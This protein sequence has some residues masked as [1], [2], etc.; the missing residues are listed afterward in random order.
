MSLGYILSEGVAGF[1]RA[2]LA[3]FTSITSLV[4]SVLVLGVLARVGYGLYTLGAGLKDDVDIEVFLASSSEAADREVGR[5]LRQLEWVESV[6][7][8][9]RDSAAAVFL[10]EF[11]ADGTPLVELDFLPASYR[12]RP[13]SELPAD[14]IAARVAELERLDDVDE[15]VFNLALLRLLES[16]LETFTLGGAVLGAFILFVSLILVFNTIRLTIYARRD[17]I[18]TMKL[19]GATNAFIRSPFMVEGLLQG[20][21]AGMMAFALLDP[22]FRYLIPVQL[23]QIGVMPWPIGRWYVLAGAMVLLSLLTGLLGSA[24]AS[25]RFI[26]QV[27]AVRDG[28]RLR[29]GI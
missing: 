15:I 3:A 26:S 24:W 22:I 6:A 27:R 8:I 17:M 12:I 18:R 28:D 21:I 14:S 25:S 2:K 1:R 19:V 5:H 20:L 10:R 23:P 4:L 29:K 16:R 7:Y 9:S 11:G 13:T